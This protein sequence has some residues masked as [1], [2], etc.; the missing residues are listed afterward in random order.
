MQPSLDCIL[1]SRIPTFPRPQLKAHSHF[2]RH[3][4]S[5]PK[6]ITK[7]RW[8]RPGRGGQN[9]SERFRRLE[10][11]LRGKGAFTRKVAELSQV[12]DVAHSASQYVGSSGLKRFALPEQPKPPAEDEC[13]MSGCAICV[14]DLYQD[15]LTAYDESINSL[16]VLL[17]SSH[18][19]ESE[20]PPDIRKSSQGITAEKRKDVV[21]SAF[22]EM[23]RALK[24]K[25][26]RRV[27]DEAGG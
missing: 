20:W 12:P 4:R 1:L 15:S 8:K 23:E 3:Y 2:A 5:H 17:S 26:E 24:E 27:K 25:Q 6:T 11:T 22:E 16:R 7:E 19:P 18:I 14:Y 13:C 21:L 9:L 10:N